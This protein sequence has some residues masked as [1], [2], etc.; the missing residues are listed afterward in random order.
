M[1]SSS[2]FYKFYNNGFYRDYISRTNKVLEGIIR[3]LYNKSK[4]LDSSLNAKDTLFHKTNALLNHN[5]D[6]NIFRVKLD[7][8]RQII[9]NPETHQIFTNFGVNNAEDATNEVL[10]F[11]NIVI[12]FFY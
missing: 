8:Y 7:T 11:L 3:L 4:S 1:N 2:F 6:S 10:I 5:K 9:R 12:P